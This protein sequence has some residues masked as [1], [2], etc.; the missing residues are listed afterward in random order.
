MDITEVLLTY[1]RTNLKHSVGNI[2]KE[3]SLSGFPA[4]DISDIINDDEIRSRLK[5]ESRTDELH[6]LKAGFPCNDSLAIET[7]EKDNSVST[8]SK[9]RSQTS[10][11]YIPVAVTVCPKNQLPKKQSKKGIPR[12]EL[13]ELMF[14]PAI[15]EYFYASVQDGKFNKITPSLVLSKLSAERLQR[16][17]K[18]EQKYKSVI[19][20]L[21]TFIAQ[22]YETFRLHFTR[23]SQLQM[24]ADQAPELLHLVLPIAEFNRRYIIGGLL[25]ATKAEVFEDSR[26]L[27]GKTISA[28]S[29]AIEN[30]L[31]E[32]T[33]AGQQ[34]GCYWSLVEPE[35]DFTL[36][37]LTEAYSKIAASKGQT[38]AELFSEALL[39]AYRQSSLN[40]PQPKISASSLVSAQM[41]YQVTDAMLKEKPQLATPSSKTDQNGVNKVVGFLAGNSAYASVEDYEDSFLK[42]SPKSDT[43]A[44]EL[45][46]GQTTVLIDLNPDAILK[47]G[48]DVKSLE[49]PHKPI[50]SQP[51]TRSSIVLRIEPGRAL[52][53]TKAKSA[54]KS[55]SS[56]KSATASN[57]STK[58]AAVRLEPNLS[59]GT[60][61]KSLTRVIKA[62]KN[63]T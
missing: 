23:S 59:T 2:M 28:L 19:H 48:V 52:N 54:P 41:G 6:I 32:F 17:S 43:Q 27:V 18:Y 14:F 46:T 30:R 61:A 26:A 8:G 1:Y 5:W 15:S 58:Q 11:Y 37:D 49:E 29:W 12:D 3:S 21:V 36:H 9:K 53:H 55:R 24:Q 33:Q 44:R 45:Q 16:I 35:S 13:I 34:L 22:S 7:I 38:I 20:R 10:T 4:M 42:S 31:Y 47:P 40:N 51:F 39:L 62:G 60:R 25:H 57:V 50:S 63:K 56:T